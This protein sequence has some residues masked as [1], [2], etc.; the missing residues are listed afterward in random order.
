VR[1]RDPIQMHDFLSLTVLLDWK[2]QRGL[3]ERLV[4]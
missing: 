4:R 1:S 3:W 2:T